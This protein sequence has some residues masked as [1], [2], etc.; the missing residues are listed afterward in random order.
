LQRRHHA[1]KDA[2]VRVQGTDAAVSDAAGS[3][4]EIVVNVG[5]GEHRPGGVM[6][7]GGVD[8]PL[9]VFQLSVSILLHSKS[10]VARGGGKVG[11]SSNTAKPPEDFEIY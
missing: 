7:L 4:G 5:G 2:L 3:V 8:P 10:L 1:E 9:A 11:Y 6:G